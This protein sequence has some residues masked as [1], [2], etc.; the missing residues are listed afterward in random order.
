M[1][2]SEEER[3][4]PEESRSTFLGEIQGPGLDWE[5]IERCQ[6]KFDSGR[7]L[8]VISTKEAAGNE[9]L[10]LK[11][12]EGMQLERVLDGITSV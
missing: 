8:F 9:F 12:D 3:E 10:V 7:G 2:G 4:N 5:G 1:K 6:Q 11:S